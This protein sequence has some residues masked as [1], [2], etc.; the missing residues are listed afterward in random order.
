ML[1]PGIPLSSPYCRKSHGNRW[2]KLSLLSFAFFSL[3]LSLSPPLSPSLSL[4][5][6]P[7]LSL[8]LFLS[9][10]LSPSVPL[11][12]PL[13]L[14]LFLSLSLSLC[15]NRGVSI[16]SVMCQSILAKKSM[17][18][19]SLK[20]KGINYSVRTDRIVLCLFVLF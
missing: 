12:L 3:S 6:P 18:P 20:E 8:Y 4:S 13:S 7:S 19:V 2:G 17:L 5:L 14:S 1:T 16:D 11:S 9:I 10:S 15:T